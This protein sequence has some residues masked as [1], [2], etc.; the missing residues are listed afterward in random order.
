MKRLILILIIILLPFTAF[1]YLKNEYAKD[2]PSPGFG[3]PLLMEQHKIDHL[4]IGS[5]TFRKGLD[6]E[7]LQSLLGN[8]YILSY[9]GNQPISMLM[10]L[11]YLLEHNVE[12]KNLYIDFYPLTVAA[13]PSLSDTRL[14]L[15]TDIDFK[16]KLYHKLYLSDDGTS[17]RF[18]EKVSYFYEMYVSSNNSVVLLWPLYQRINRSRN[19]NG[20]LRN[21]RSSHGTTK[22]KLEKKELHH[23]RNHVLDVQLE[24]LGK[25]MD[26][27]KLHHI[28]L[29][30]LEI[31]KYEK[32]YSNSNYVELSR[33]TISY[34]TH[35][36]GDAIILNVNE[37]TFD[38][39]EPNNFTDFVHLSGIGAHTFSKSFVD[40]MIRLKYT[41]NP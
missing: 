14:L 32:L 24:A 11:E 30:F 37:F 33:D 40:T 6:I 7:I 3:I 34:I 5:S 19:L 4:F 13:T 18:T 41:N 38:L 35:K 8:S 1:I 22:E 17:Y 26:L 15:D 28:R 25:I 16:S 29:F 20:G 21:L 31:P 2:L 23:T 10:E 36:D 9:N 39:K 27:A 12:I